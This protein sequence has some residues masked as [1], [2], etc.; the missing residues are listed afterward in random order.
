VRE[1]AKERHKASPSAELK[2]TL[3]SYG[4]SEDAHGNGELFNKM[5]EAVRTYKDTG[6]DVDLMG[7]VHDGGGG[8]GGGADGGARTPVEPPL[9]RVLERLV[10]EHRSHSD[11]SSTKVSTAF[12]TLPITLTFVLFF[13]TF[14]ADGCDVCVCVCV[15]VCVR[16]SVCVYR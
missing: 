13:L 8:V 2:K 1:Q 6:G 14:V 3:L 12:S 11:D 10:R 4:V 16:M 7:G 15:C 5:K 9:S